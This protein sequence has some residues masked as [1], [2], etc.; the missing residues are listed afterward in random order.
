MLLEGFVRLAVLLLH[1]FWAFVYMLLSFCILYYV[2]KLLHVHIK[3]F[4][5]VYFS[6]P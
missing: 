2:S 3:I 5:S 1:T 4:R 6:K